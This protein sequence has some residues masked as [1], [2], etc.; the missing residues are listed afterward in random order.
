MWIII[1]S[2]LLT[3]QLPAVLDWWKTLPCSTHGWDG[4]DNTT[5]PA[6]TQRLRQGDRSRSSQA[7]Q[8]DPVSNRKENAPNNS[9]NKAKTR[10]LLAVNSKNRLR[11]GYGGNCL[12]KEP[13]RLGAPQVLL[14]FRGKPDISLNIQPS[15]L[16][17]SFSLLLHFFIFYIPF[18]PPHLLSFFLLPSLPFLLW[19]WGS[20]DFPLCPCVIFHVLGL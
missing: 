8:Q 11:K 20:S 13:S 16:L 19:W 12:G 15:F 18:V 6:S 2:V 5:R 10:V 17:H 3:S 14:S 4:P 9:N 7:A 1:F